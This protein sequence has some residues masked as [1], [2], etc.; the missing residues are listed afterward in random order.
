MGMSNTLQG[1]LEQRHAHF[2]LMPH[3]HT[4][5]SID[6]A[7]AAHVPSDK[8]A[9]PVIL[10]DNIGYV[11]A[12]IPASRQVAIRE[13]NRW[14]GRHLHLADEAELRDIFRDCELGAIPPVGPAWGLQTVMDQ[15]L[16][17]SDQIYFEAGDHEELIRT[18]MDT[19]LDL[20]AE[21]DCARFTRQM[22]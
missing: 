9:K 2:D 14:M 5:C 1:Y 12:V 7:V 16:I 21:A 3:T 4:Y 6:T 20:M 11:M 18:D 8:V 10:K 17:D 13:L 19:F 15:S 22:N